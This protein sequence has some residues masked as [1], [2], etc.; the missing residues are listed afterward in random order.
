MVAAT[1]TEATHCSPRI[2]SLDTKEELS[3]PSSENVMTLTLIHYE[4]HKIPNSRSMQLPH[5]DKGPP[6]VLLLFKRLTQR[7]A[8]GRS[9]PSLFNNTRWM[10]PQPREPS[11]VI[12]SPKCPNLSV[13]DYTQKPLI[14]SAHG[15]LIQDP[16]RKP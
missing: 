2:G 6:P 5:E 14:S 10:R 7:V 15:E 4:A 8:C 11:T 12:L 3:L 1:L 9:I 16:G 13:P